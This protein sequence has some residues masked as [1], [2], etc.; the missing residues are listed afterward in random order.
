VR[1]APSPLRV[2]PLR[3]Q[4]VTG[5]PTLRLHSLPMPQ[6]RRRPLLSRLPVWF[7]V[8]VMC[9]L[10]AWLLFKLRHVIFWR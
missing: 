4:Q 10:L 3:R 5:L 7:W 6:H 2:N 9:A 1:T 8:V